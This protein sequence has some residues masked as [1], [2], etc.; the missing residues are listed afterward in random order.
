MTLRE[1]ILA[2]FE[3]SKGQYLS[4][5]EIGKALNVSRAGVWK[6]V[7]ALQQEGYPIHAVPNK[8][9]CLSRDSDIL[10]CQGV[11]KYLRHNALQVQVQ[12]KV[13]STNQAVKALAQEKAGTDAPFTPPRAPAFISA[14]CCGP[15]TGPR[16]PPWGLP[17]W[18]RWLSAG[19]LKQFPGSIPR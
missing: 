6:A 19:P 13:S 8:G 11:Q 4:G 2:L 7:K 18:L 10:S 14:C 12:D 5:E 16:N 15:G 3:S 17:P 1:R 9:Y